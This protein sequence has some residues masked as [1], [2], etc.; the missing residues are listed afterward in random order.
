[1]GRTKPE[2]GSMVIG[3]ESMKSGLGR[4]CSTKSQGGTVRAPGEGTWVRKDRQ[5]N[6][7]H[8]PGEWQSPAR[9][10]PA[11]AVRSW[12]KRIQRFSCQSCSHRHTGDSS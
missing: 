6:C 1:M 8:D 3:C 10:R 2:Y 12:Q 9:A 11:M 4:M 7:C 5:Q